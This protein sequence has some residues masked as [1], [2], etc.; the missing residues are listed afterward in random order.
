MRVCVMR[1]LHACACQSGRASVR[2]VHARLRACASKPHWAV[3]CCCGRCPLVCLFVCLF[4]CLPVRLLLQAE[5]A[6]ASD[7]R[8]SQRR[9][10][11]HRQSRLQSAR[12]RRPC[13]LVA[14]PAAARHR[15]NAQHAARSTQDSTAAA[16]QHSAHRSPQLKRNRVR[17]RPCTHAR[18]TSCARMNTRR[19]CHA[20]LGTQTS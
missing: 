15:C 8:R 14:C 2:H 12:S 7:R 4:V 1:A 18:A 13:R 10:G 11:R 6:E 16:H 19:K 3:A 5:I 17:A 9:R 20:G